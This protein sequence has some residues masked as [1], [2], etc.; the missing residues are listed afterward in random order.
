MADKRD[1]ITQ[2]EHDATFRVKK[3]SNY[4]SDGNGNLVREIADGFAIGNYDYIELTYVASGDGEGEIET[5]VYKTGGAS[6][7]VLSTLTL[8]YNS[9][10][11]LTS[12]TRS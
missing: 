2:Q 5:V 4:V 1:F 10:N 11:C 9:D 3:V 12:V 7:T 8:G 6:G